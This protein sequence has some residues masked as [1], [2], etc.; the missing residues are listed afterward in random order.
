MITSVDGP[1][2]RPTQAA[3]HLQR[4]NQFR[5][6]VGADANLLAEDGSRRGRWGEADHVATVLGPGQ[7]EGAHSSVLP[8]RE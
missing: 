6:R 4:P 7:G 8:A 2:G 5:E 1:I 3:R